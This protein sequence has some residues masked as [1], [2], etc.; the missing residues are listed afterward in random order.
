[1]KRLFL[2]TILTSLALVVTSCVKTLP[3]RFE[4]FVDKV[5]QNAGTLSFN[6]WEEAYLQ[7][8]K[9]DSELNEAKNKLP[10]DAI[11]RINKAKER[12]NNAYLVHEFE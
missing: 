3:S 5:E 4:K 11:T 10:Y 7:F 8:E 6:D 12:F 2:I 1:M 9:F